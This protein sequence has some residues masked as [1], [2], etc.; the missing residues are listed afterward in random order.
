MKQQNRILHCCLN[1]FYPQAI[2]IHNNVLEIFPFSATCET[3]GDKSMD[4]W[5]AWLPMSLK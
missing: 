2:I 3:K 5:P 1:Q 4:K